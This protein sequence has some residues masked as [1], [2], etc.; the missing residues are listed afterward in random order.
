MNTSVLNQFKG[1]HIAFPNGSNAGQC[2]AVAV[3]YL[4]LNNIPVPATMYG[5]RADGWGVQFPAQLAPYF[6]HEAYQSD[7]AYPIGTI[8]MWNSPHIVVTL[9]VPSGNTVQ[10]FEQNADPN[11]SVC[12]VYTR[13]ITTSSRQCTYALVPIP[14]QVS[15]PQ[16]VIEMIANDTQAHQMYQLLRPNGDGS[17][18]EIADTAGQRTFADFLTA[19]QP[20]V[21]WRNSNLTAQ[22]ATAVSLQ[23]EVGSL[24]AQVTGLTTTNTSDQQQLQV[25]LAKVTALT[26]Q[27]VTTTKTAVPMTVTAVNDTVVSPTSSNWFTSF[28]KLFAKK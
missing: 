28:L 13:T 4:Q 1:K 18:T 9:A 26:N 27:L 10:V 5:N 15:Q 17:T 21:T 16:E 14:K 25:A 6:T 11:G 19:A 8:L 20:E 7:K 2:T 23:T 24:T 12:Q 3:W 22:A